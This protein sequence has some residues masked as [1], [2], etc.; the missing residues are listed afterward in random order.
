MAKLDV[1]LQML[2]EQF[3]EAL[4]EAFAAKFDKLEIETTYNVI[5]GCYVSTPKWVEAE[6]SYA[7][8]FTPEHQAFIGGF[9][10]AWLKASNIV[11]EER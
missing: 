8:K 5:H 6:D 11:A 10:A 7:F 2:R 9:E 4:R 1:A 3:T